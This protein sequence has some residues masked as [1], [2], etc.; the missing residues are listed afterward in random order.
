MEDVSNIIKKTCPDC[1]RKQVAI[2]DI[3]WKPGK[4][5]DPM[6]RRFICTECRANFFQI[7]NAKELMHTKG[8]HSAAP[9]SIRRTG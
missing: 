2:M 4:G 3:S 9:L 8:Y 5:L 6:L 1:H 7:I